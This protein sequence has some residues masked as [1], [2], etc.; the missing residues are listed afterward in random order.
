MT[1]RDS[2]TTEGIDR[3]LM[4][5]GTAVAGLLGALPGIASATANTITIQGTGGVAEYRFTVSGEVVETGG[6]PGGEDR[7]IDHGKTAVGKVG[8]HGKDTFEF[9]GHITSFEFPKG[10]ADV[11]VNG[12][13]VSV[14]EKLPNEIHVEAKGKHVE[15][16]FRVSGRVAAGEWADD[17]DDVYDHRKV[18]GS[19]DDDEVD[20]FRYSGDLTFEEPDGPLKVTLDID[21]KEDH[22]DDH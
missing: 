5:K 21:P 15:Y 12:K 3:R 9:T 17:H 7:V 20:S 1:D 6:G 2:E 19:V 18:R 13:R 4:L 10:S 11:Y 8:G 14:H 22:D 16:E